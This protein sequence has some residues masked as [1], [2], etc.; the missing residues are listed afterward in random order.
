MYRVVHVLEDKVLLSFE[1][2]DP[3]IQLGCRA[4]TLKAIQ[5]VDHYKRHTTK[6]YTRVHGPPCSV[7]D[8]PPPCAAVGVEEDGVAGGE[9]EGGR[10]EETAANQRPP[11][12]AVLENQ[13]K[14]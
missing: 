8:D 7:H 4:A 10:D 11:R 12:R 3:V 13:Q 1:E 6:P 9:L 5:P 2:A 14:L